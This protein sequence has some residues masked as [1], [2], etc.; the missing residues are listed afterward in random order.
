MVLSHKDFSFLRGPLDSGPGLQSS[1]P[2]FLIEVTRLNLRA[3]PRPQLW[4]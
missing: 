1:Y 3:R 2:L 4:Y